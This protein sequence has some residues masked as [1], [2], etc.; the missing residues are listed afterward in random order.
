[1]KDAVEDL[2]ENTVEDLVDDLI[3]EVAPDLPVDLPGSGGSCDR[4]RKPNS[5]VPGT[6]VLMADGSTRAIE[7][8]RVG[9]QVAA[10]DPA[11]GVTGARPVTTLI[12]GDGVKDLVG[13][14]IDVDGSRGDAVDVVT[15]TDEHPFW[16]P[17]L[18][19]WV[20]AGDL[21][22][23]MWL[24]TSAGTHVQITALKKWTTTQRVHNLTVD[25]LHTYHVVAGDQAILVH[26]AGPG[27]GLGDDEIYLWRAVQDPELAG[28]HGNRSYHN[29]LGYETKYFAF[30]EEG[31]REYGRRAYGVRPQEGPYTVT[32]TT[33]QKG[34]IP[35]SSIMPPTADVP[36]GGVA[37]PTDLL[38]DLGRPRIMPQSSC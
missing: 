6:R 19:E 13:V 25:D 7:D 38:D 27:R 8:I 32:R 37:L 15:A 21:K 1:M 30:T 9:D 18:R 28:I 12:T 26:N 31:A 2:V 20:N 29:P 23:G 34:K 10:T 24:R 4:G 11:S 3:D 5:F 16:V 33:I 35:P 14:T 36:G 17:S 22:P